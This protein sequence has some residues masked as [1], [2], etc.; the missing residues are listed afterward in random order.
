MSG[1]NPDS[2]G[3]PSYRS[4]GSVDTRRSRD[5][6]VGSFSH[7]TNPNLPRSEIKFTLRDSLVVFKCLYGAGGDECTPPIKLV[8]K[9]VNNVNKV[10]NNGAQPWMLVVIVPDSGP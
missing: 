5:Q 7:Q 6:E 10:G 1:F 9:L 8:N 4:R 3:F 2:G